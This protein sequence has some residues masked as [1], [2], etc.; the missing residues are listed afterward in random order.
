MRL[1]FCRAAVIGV[2]GV[3]AAGAGAPASFALDAVSVA[4]PQA[5]KP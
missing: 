4:M 2:V 1:P 3:L 5:V